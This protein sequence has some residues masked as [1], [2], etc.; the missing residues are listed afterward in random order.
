MV[1]TAL[2]AAM[3]CSA[4]SGFST[5][6]RLRG[7]WRNGTAVAEQEDGIELTAASPDDGQSFIRWNYCVSGRPV[8][9]VP[10]E[11][12]AELVEATKVA[13]SHGY[14]DGSDCLVCE[15]LHAV[16]RAALDSGLV[17]L[18]DNLEQVGAIN[19]YGSLAPLTSLPAPSPH[20]YGPGAEWVPVFR[21]VESKD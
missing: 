2:C 17:I 6:Y 16:L 9:D 14:C 10:R 15:M 3:A 13:L 11:L 8:V 19:G 7:R 12:P 5:P 20:A 18:R 4:R 1:I 21:V